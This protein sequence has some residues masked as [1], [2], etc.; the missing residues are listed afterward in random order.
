M[1]W[2]LEA[3]QKGGGREVGIVGTFSDQCH[4]EAGPLGRQKLSPAGVAPSPSALGLVAS[5]SGTPS[6]SSSLAALRPP[7]C[8]FSQSQQ[9]LPHG[10]CRHRP[11]PPG[12]RTPPAQLTGNT[13]QMLGPR[14]TGGGG[15]AEVTE[16]QGGR[17]GC[18]LGVQT[19]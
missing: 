6:T 16:V 9:Q 18:W 17:G 10:S 7:T 15:W 19:G 1:E 4:A 14:P 11:L 12:S 3:P 8:W 2:Q 5:L 13:N